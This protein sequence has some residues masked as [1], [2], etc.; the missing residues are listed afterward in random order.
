[1]FSH[2]FP[3]TRTS[4]FLPLEDNNLYE[5]RKISLIYEVTAN[6]LHTHRY[7]DHNQRVMYLGPRERKKN[8]FSNSLKARM[9]SIAFIQTFSKEIV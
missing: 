1:M 4:E 3:L 9:N 7:S 6:I 2:V 8:Y 5:K